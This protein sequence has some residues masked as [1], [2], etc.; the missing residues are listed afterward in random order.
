MASCL[1]SS[2]DPALAE[3]RRLREEQDA[4]L[5]EALLKDRAKADATARAEASVRDATA[6]L[7]A[8]PAEEDPKTL[9]IAIQLPDGEQ[10]AR[11]FPPYAKV[12]AL[13]DL[14]TASD[15]PVPGAAFSKVAA[16]FSS[17]GLD[18]SAATWNMTLAELKLSRRSM[19]L[20]QR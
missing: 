13:V 16:V 18:L 3:R 19:F 6:R 11:R 9:C 17:P 20:L 2:A 4:E 5:Q 15:V 1:R 8:E 7:P 12:R 10:L 14:V